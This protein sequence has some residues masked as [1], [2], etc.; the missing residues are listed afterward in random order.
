MRSELSLFW[1]HCFIFSYD[2]VTKLKTF[3][4][5]FTLKQML[6][7]QRQEVSEGNNKQRQQN[8]QTTMNSQ[9]GEDTNIL[10]QE[11]SSNCLL[12]HLRRQNKAGN[13]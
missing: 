11:R 3:Y 7:K 1:P 6:Q 5:R 2:I 9:K 10:L 8:T 13:K 4:H 12:G